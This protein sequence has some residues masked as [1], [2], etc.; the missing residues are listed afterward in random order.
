MV[1]SVAFSPDGKTIAA[2]F[3]HLAGV[4]GGGVV[5][6]HAA[7]GK[8]L[9]YAP[10]DTKGELVSSVAFSPD[11]NTIAA[12]YGLQP[13]PVGGGVVLWDVASGKRLMDV[14]LEVKEGY[15]LS[16][17]FSPDGTT[18]ATGYRRIVGSGGVVV[19]WDAAGRKRL[20]D[21]PLEVKEGRVSSVAFSPDG[22]TIAA[23]YEGV[24]GG[25]G[26]VGGVVVWDTAG[27]K[28]PVDAP[29]EV[30]E[31]WVSSV[32]FSPDGK[33]IAAAYGGG[34]VLCDVTLESWQSIAAQIANRNL[35]R[36]EWRRYF[37]DEPYHATFPDLRVPP[38]ETPR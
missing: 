18:I 33:T 12:A 4:G 19:L 3:Y 15:G 26:G 13:R 28:R 11:G 32:V 14:P 22:K 30:R 25:L 10:L 23:G 20:V 5:L 9:A 2:G 35:T 16:V 24:V 17:A 38:E 21:A 36:A 34:V 6:W 7:A 27:R 37:P 8:R 29:L 1:S 31:G